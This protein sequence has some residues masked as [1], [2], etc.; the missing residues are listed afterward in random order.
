MGFVKLVSSKQSVDKKNKKSVKGYKRSIAFIVAVPLFI[1][2]AIY[3][4]LLIS[5]ISLQ[6]FDKQLNDIAIDSLPKGFEV[7]LGNPFLALEAAAIPVIKFSPV[8]F[9]DSKTRAKIEMESLDIGF[10]PLNAIFGQPGVNITLLQP[11]IKII[12]DLHGPR[13]GE[14]EFIED[15]EGKDAAVWVME[16]ENSFPLVDITSKGIDVTG[17]APK[18]SQFQFRSDND[19]MIA[20]FTGIF[21]GLLEFERLNK[22]GKISSLKIINGNIDMHDSVY[23]LFRQLSNIH[24]EISANKHGAIGKFTTQIAN[25]E[26]KS[27]FSLLRNAGSKTK[28]IANLINIDFA[29]LLTFLDDPRSLIAVKGGGN[30]EINIDYDENN[31]LIEKG[32]FS[33][34]PINS[35]LRIQDDFFPLVIENLNA[36]WFPKE[37]KFT[38]EKTKF[39]V[40]K[41]YATAGGE[42]FLGFDES[43]GPTLSMVIKASDVNIHINNLKAQK[44][45]FDQ[46]NFSGWVAPLYG[47]IGIDQIIVKKPDALLWAKGRADLLQKGMGINIE[48]G[49][50][51]SSVDDLKR[52]WPYFIASTARKWFVKNAKDGIVN[53]ASMQLNFPSGS[54]PVNDEEMV[55]PNGAIKIDLSGRD[56]KFIPWKGLNPLKVDGE[57]TLKMRDY[58]TTVTMQGATQKTK[59]GD[60]DFTNSAIIIDGERAGASVFELSGDIAGSLSSIISLGDIILPNKLDELNIP[61]DVNNLEGDVKGSLVATFVVPDSNNGEM[62][63]IDYAANGV[64]N[65]FNSSDNIGGYS[66]DSGSFSFSLNQAGYN[67]NGAAQIADIDADIIV[68]GAID[69]EQKVIISTELSIKELKDLGFDASSFLKGKVRVIAQPLGDGLLKLSANLKDAQINFTDLGLQKNIGVAGLLEAKVL[70]ANDKI[71]ISDLSLSFA[72]IRIAGDMLID[73]NNG[74]QSANFSTFSLSKMDN[75]SLIVKPSKNG[76]ALKIRGERMDLKPM[77]KR[78]FALDQPSVGGVQSTQYAKTLLLDIELKQAIGFYGVVAHNFDLNMNLHG[79]DLRNVSLQ[80]QFSQGNS[81]SIVTNPIQDGRIMS[82]AFADAGT[83]LR[84]LNI[85]PRLLGGSGTLSMTTDAK[86]N[87]D[88]GEI[89]LSNFSLID[90]SK[91][92]EILGNHSDSRSIVA[93]ENRVNFKFGKVNFIRKK[94]QTE[95]IDGVL[96]GGEVGGTLRGFINTK[97]SVYDLTGTYIPLFGLNSIFQKIPLFGVILGGREGEGLIGVTFAIRGPL[98]KPEFIINPAS[99]LA[100]GMFRSLFEFRSREGASPQ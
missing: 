49:G 7:E 85:Y 31:N 88:T 95:I 74:F 24:F 13:L 12:Q 37:A 58:A 75:A 2:L 19:L 67:F 29:S 5:P 6:M 61:I 32:I 79:T 81:V 53:S 93:N 3:I 99:I 71:K 56:V 16:G 77:L 64:V 76:L 57:V 47:A 87:V 28:L 63:Q 65:N 40:G 59:N 80:T 42:F 90:E 68:E 21:A 22:Q 52:L 10:S 39:L 96:D 86:T 60:V 46:I 94:G 36:L 34:K 69:G 62:E 97:D 55:I 100:P 43:F 27:D 70:Q 54:L 83:L 72:D 1:L 25:R 18:E 78:A 89:N 82:M 51:G 41:S 35:N 38:I 84:F 20:N 14:F 91:I 98:N 92:A 73:N 9:I 30:I 45:L 4:K 33:I 44:H 26:V 17:E 48:I 66:F 15:S 23:G 50:E 11:K 8:T